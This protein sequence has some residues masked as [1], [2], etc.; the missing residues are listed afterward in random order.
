[1]KNG[2]RVWWHAWD[3]KRYPATVIG[4]G[5]KNGRKLYDIELLNP[6]SAM[7]R[8]RWGYAEQLSPLSA[9]E[10]DR[11]AF[12]LQYGDWFGGSR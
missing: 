2:T 6:A 12:Q 10:N 5:E 1:M 4:N 8:F 3:G 7:E 9:S 11:V